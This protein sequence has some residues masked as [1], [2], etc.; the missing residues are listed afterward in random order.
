MADKVILTGIAKQGNT[1][2]ASTTLSSPSY[3]WFR[4]GIV[5]MGNNSPSYILIQADVGKNISVRIKDHLDIPPSDVV[6]VINENDL[7]TGNISILVNSVQSII[8]AKQGDKLT[9]IQSIADVDGMGTISY[10]WFRN[11]KPISNE[12]LSEYTLASDDINKTISVH[13]LYTDLQNT[14]EEIISSGVTVAA[15]LTQVVGTGTITINGV[16]KQD[17]TINA[18]YDIIDSNGFNENT[19]HYQWLNDNKPISNATKSTL[20]LIPSLAS[21]NISVKVSY[22]DFLGKLETISSDQIKVINVN[23]SPT[24]YVSFDVNGKEKI[25]QE[26]KQGD[27][28]SAKNTLEDK[29]GLG[30][31]SYQW[32]SNGKEIPNQTSA[33]YTLTTADINKN[34]SVHARYTDQLGTAEDESSQGFNVMVDTNKQQ[35]PTGNVTIT[36]TA[37]QN[38]ILKAEN[39]L[40]DANGFGDNGIQYQWF[41]DGIGI[42]GANTLSYQL[43]QEDVG[44]NIIVVASYADYSNTHESKQSDKVKVLNVNDAPSGAVSLFLNEKEATGAVIQGNILTAVNTLQDKDGLG[45]TSYQWFSNGKEIV[46]QISKTYTLK[47]LDVDKTISVHARYVDLQGTAEDISSFGL[48]VLDILPSNAVTIE[49][50]AN[51]G[52]TL[53]ASYTFPNLDELGKLSYQ[54]FSDNLPIKDATNPTY[55][56]SEGDDGKEI[57][58]KLSYKD[59]QGDVKTIESTLYIVAS[60]NPDFLPTGEVIISGTP[61]QNSTLKAQNTLEDK[62]G[63]DSST[64]HYQW[65]RNDQDISGEKNLTYTLTQLDVGKQITVKASYTDYQNN[66]QSLKS[67][68]VVIINVNDL[69]TGNIAISLNNHILT[70]FAYIKDLDGTGL[71]KYQWLRDGHLIAHDTAKTHNLVPADEGK[72]LSVEVSYIDLGGTTEH[73][74]GSSVNIAGPTFGN[75]YLTGTNKSDKILALS[76][77]DT[78]FGSGGADILSGGLGADTFKFDNPTDTGINS[79]TRDTIKD[80]KTIEGDKIDL[81][82][83]KKNYLPQLKDFKWIGSN[84]FTSIDSTGELRFDNKAHILYGSLNKDSAPEFSIQLCGVSKLTINDFLL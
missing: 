19:V 29:D 56:L 31:I 8:E 12:A 59:L 26:I 47:P 4:D 54:W 41:R 71:Y 25:S 21:Q 37:K 62:N 15:K 34:I 17:N 38:V 32:F 67:H 68:G 1:L 45:V 75:D 69:P 39:D 74:Q 57:K 16:V 79:K 66:T 76:G 9:A 73:M 30:G 18:T 52:N 3:Q 60:S 14:A 80:F 64:V 7:P 22:T 83:M 20:Q 23:D 70:A 58:L 44:S 72:S 33:I 27:I 42:L 51:I 36:G 78:I 61:K 77:D 2:T 24:G 63:I 35:L 82:D 10:Q 43:T 5:V 48:K 11:G 40:A 13:A 28:L 49:G 65:L 81:S 84:P 46:G 50:I 55:T 6:R 53:N